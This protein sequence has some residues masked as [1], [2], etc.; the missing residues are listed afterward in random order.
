MAG[1]FGSIALDL[2]HIQDHRMVDHTVNR[3]EGG[4]RVL[5]DSVPLAKDQIGGQHH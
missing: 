1:F 5:E 4:H 3:S 2:H